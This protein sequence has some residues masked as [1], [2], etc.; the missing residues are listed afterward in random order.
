M[1]P[2]QLS[3]AQELHMSENLCKVQRELNVSTQAS[4][5]SPMWRQPL[6]SQEFLVTSLLPH[7]MMSKSWH[8]PTF[9]SEVQGLAFLASYE[10]DSK[11]ILAS[12]KAST[13]VADVS[14]VGPPPPSSSHE[15]DLKIFVRGCAQ[16]FINRR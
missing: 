3:T 12:L 10:H 13:I 11:I 7:A 8:A 16:G 14:N 5:N 6:L 15:H 1:N 9:L 4:K 2:E